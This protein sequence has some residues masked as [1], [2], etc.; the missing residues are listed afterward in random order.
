VGG[1]IKE[2]IWHE[3]QKIAQQ[4]DGLIIFEAEVAGT[5]EIKL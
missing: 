1:Y 2:K 3:S 4:N 5:E